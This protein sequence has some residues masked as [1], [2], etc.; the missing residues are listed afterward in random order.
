MLWLGVCWRGLTRYVNRKL[1]DKS[2]IYC[3][4]KF[5][6]G[7][8]ISVVMDFYQVDCF[9]FLYGDR[10]QLTVRDGRNIRHSTHGAATPGQGRDG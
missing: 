6:I 1:Q 3:R 5:L 7:S 8:Q 4:Y 2:S 10:T 9:E